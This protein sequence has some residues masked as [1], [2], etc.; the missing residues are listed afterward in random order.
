MADFG[1]QK[2]LIAHGRPLDA[3]MNETAHDSKGVNTKRLS[4]AKIALYSSRAQRSLWR[5]RRTL[6]VNSCSHL[7]HT[8]IRSRPSTGNRKDHP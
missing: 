5:S 8:K 3:V 1:E 4:A 6:P 2:L 7:I